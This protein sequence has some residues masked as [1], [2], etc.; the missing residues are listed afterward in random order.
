MKQKVK[1]HT[2]IFPSFRVVLAEGRKQFGVIQAG[3]AKG[4][5]KAEAANCDLKGIRKGKRELLSR[6]PCKSKWEDVRCHYVE[7][8]DWDIPGIQIKD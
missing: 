2:R 4:W 7:K 3:H 8:L 5:R 1:G 6:M